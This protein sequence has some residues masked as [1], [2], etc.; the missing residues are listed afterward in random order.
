M[1]ELNDYSGEYKPDLKFEDFSKEALIKLLLEYQKILTRLDGYWMGL[2]AEK[3]G[4]K[5]ACAFEGAVWKFMVGYDAD[6]IS[7]AMNIQGNNVE[8]FLKYQQL[9]A[10]LPKAVTPAGA[11][12]ACRIEMKDPNHGVITIEDCRA[13]AYWEKEGR[14]DW[15]NTFCRQEE[16]AIVEA[17]A[18][19]VNPAIK[20]TALKLPPREKKEDI[21]CQWEFK[22]E[23]SA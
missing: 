15:I 18:R 12:A 7:K 23:E 16:P 2:V 6:R 10:G 14:E 21:S 4:Y 13:L 22:L 8:T 3:Y 17:Y 20:M 9:T 1:A 5:E 19:H 11:Q